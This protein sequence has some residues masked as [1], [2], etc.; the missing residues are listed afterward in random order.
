MTTIQLESGRKLTVE[1]DCGG[2]VLR[3]TRRSYERAWWLTE[4]EAALLVLALT[5][6][7]PTIPTSE[8]E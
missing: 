2:Y 4:T 6:S 5:Q 3:F 7:A 1:E 8:G